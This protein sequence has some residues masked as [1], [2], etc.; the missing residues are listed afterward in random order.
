MIKGPKRIWLSK[1]T[2]LLCAM[3]S[4]TACSDNVSDRKSEILKDLDLVKAALNVSSEES[5][6]KM[7]GASAISLRLNFFGA[8]GAKASNNFVSAVAAVGYVHPANSEFV[9]TKY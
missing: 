5:V 6:V 9:L 2:L 8:E 4:L 1:T 7:E 3:L